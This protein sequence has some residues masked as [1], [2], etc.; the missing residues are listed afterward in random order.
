MKT[1]V[2]HL[3]LF[4]AVLTALFTAPVPAA[5]LPTNL[6]V[7][8]ASDFEIDAD[9]WTGTNT[10]GVNE[11]VVYKVGGATSNSVGFIGINENVN[12]GAINF[13]VAPA[14]YHGDK[15]AAYNGYLALWFRQNRTGNLNNGNRFVVFG[16]DTNFISFD[17]PI[18]PGQEWERYVIP[19][20]ENSGWHF[21][22][23][24]NDTA[25]SNQLATRDDLLRVLS[26]VDLL[27][28]KAEY[29]SN[30]G[31]EDDLDDVLLLG[32]PSG[33]PEPGV[34]IATF[35]GLTVTGAVGSTYTIEYR[36]AL[37]ASTN[38]FPLT[39]LVLPH[40]PYLFV[41]TNSPSAAS[42]FYRAVLNP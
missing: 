14:K 41:D 37:D 28:I 31:D 26:A 29:S 24:T 38:W 36:N 21:A 40:T 19:I 7:L 39:N 27:R 20:N 22:T 35:A 25:T 1:L 17:L 32:Q 11:I 23:T 4:L 42:R 5:D 13:L 18:V 2:I 15:R 12:D 16:S 30:N 34:G 8:A 6:V 10:A 33:P 3:P 9:G